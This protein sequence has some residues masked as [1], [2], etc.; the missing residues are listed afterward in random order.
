MWSWKTTWPISFSSCIYLQPCQKSVIKCDLFNRYQIMPRNIFS[1]CTFEVPFKGC[2]C[3]ENIFS[4]GSHKNSL[5]GTGNSEARNHGSRWS[6]M[7]TLYKPYWQRSY[8]DSKSNSFVGRDVYHINNAHQILHNPL[9]I[10]FVYI[11]FTFFSTAF[12]ILK[13]KKILV[14]IFK[15]RLICYRK[16][17]VLACIHWVMPY[18]STCRDFWFPITCTFK[19]LLMV[20]ILQWLVLFRVFDRILYFVTNFFHWKKFML[21]LSIPQWC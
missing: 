13:L 8:S 5:H 10:I 4:A 7:W 3:W 16:F 15:T 14:S 6:F 20:G 17:K 9:K 18:V 12:K 11:S 19:V 2:N 21:V 1:S